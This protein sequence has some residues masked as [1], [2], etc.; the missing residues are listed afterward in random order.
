M[1][2]QSAYDAWALGWLLVPWMEK[3]QKKQGIWRGHEGT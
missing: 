2:P 1:R 3:Q